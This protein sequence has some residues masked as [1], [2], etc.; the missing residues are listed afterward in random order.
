MPLDPKTDPMKTSEKKDWP[1]IP[2]DV[3]QVQI[4]DLTEFDD[5]YKGEVKRKFKFEFTLIEDGQFYGRK[6]WVR[7]SKVSPCPSSNN[8]A[9]ITWKVASAVLKHPLTEDEGKSFTIA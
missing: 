2:E 7:G 6:L 3:Y 9:P 4:T 5:D 1:I 8:K